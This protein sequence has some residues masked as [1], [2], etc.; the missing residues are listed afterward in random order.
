MTS[1]IRPAAI[2]G[3]KAAAEYL[4]CSEATLKRYEEDGLIVPRRHGR[5]QR[6]LAFLLADLDALLAALPD[7]RR[8]S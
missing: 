7:E 3:R 6:G 4:G 8:V 2:G 1:P 5:R